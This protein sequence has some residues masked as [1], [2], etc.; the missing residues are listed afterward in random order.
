MPNTPINNTQDKSPQDV[1]AEGKQSSQDP[2]ARG[3]STTSNQNERTTK[4]DS[5]YTQGKVRNDPEP[6][7]SREKIQD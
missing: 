5:D 7:Y 4:P 6:E 3:F 2:H 1:Y